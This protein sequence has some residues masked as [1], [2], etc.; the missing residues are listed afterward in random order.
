[1][2]PH[3]ILA[4]ADLLETQAEALAAQARSLKALVRFMLVN[5]PIPAA[6]ERRDAFH[7][8]PMVCVHPKDGLV[9]VAAMDHPDELHCTACG[10]EVPA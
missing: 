9:K 5:E 7:H 6:T 2:D 10:A 3:A 8:G 4:Q 1:M